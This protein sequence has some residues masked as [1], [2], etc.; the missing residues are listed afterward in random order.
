LSPSR[1]S[2]LAFGLALL[3]LLVL[4]PATLASRSAAARTTRPSSP[5]L[6]PSSPR[7]LGVMTDPWHSDEYERALKTHVQVIANFIPFGSRDLPT[8]RLGEA[9]RR[10]LTPMISWL[11]REPSSK[12]NPHAVQPA[13]SN[14]AIASGRQDRY[15]RRFARAC[16][17]FDG[18]VLLR[19]APEFEGP[20][21]PWHVNP[22]AYVRAWKRVHRIFRQE[23]AT[24]VKFVWSPALPWQGY[25]GG[26]DA[27][28]KLIRRYWPGTGLV[29]YVGATMVSH[30]GQGVDFFAERIPLLRRYGKP[31]VLAEVH[32][33]ERLRATWLPDLA[34]MV[35]WMPWVRIVVWCDLTP[36]TP[37]T[38]SPARLALRTIEHG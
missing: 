33:P 4:S 2:S 32:A 23:G 11:P 7:L 38:A 6:V 36:K 16:A 8:N 12:A 1:A 15:I 37:I 27:W 26:F 30:N 22:V 19:Y 9:Q 28:L 3:M 17:R 24:N 31:I 14:A 10:G 21:E 29:D 34:T 13:F 25:R 35:N 5:W 20:W 18:S